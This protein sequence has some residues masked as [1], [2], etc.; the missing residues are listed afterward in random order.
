MTANMDHENPSS[1][2]NPNI[3]YQILIL[4]LT[5]F[6]LKTKSQKNIYSSFVFV[7]IINEIRTSLKSISF[8]W[9]FV[10]KN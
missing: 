7:F 2:L 9:T 5:I 10:T 3:I 6:I 1:F 8:D 4:K